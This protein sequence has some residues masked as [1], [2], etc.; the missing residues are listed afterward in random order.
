MK[1]IAA[2]SITAIFAVTFLTC[3]GQAGTEGAVRSVGPNP[4]GAAR[5]SGVRSA[6]NA[7]LIDL[8]CCW[9]DES[10]RVPVQE[11][12]GLPEDDGLPRPEH[13]PSAPASFRKGVGDAQDSSCLPAGNEMPYEI[14]WGSARGVVKRHHGF[15][16][17]ADELLAAS[18][19]IQGDPRFDYLRY[20]INDFMD[21]EDHAGRHDGDRV[22]L[23]AC[24]SAAR[25]SIGRRSLPLSRPVSPD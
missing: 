21:V 24:G 15:L 7:A 9:A 18:R 14:I 25:R 2:Q 23:P 22:F 5:T 3:N 16:C 12:Q 6:R 1:T 10:Y 4:S 13:G 20:I 17:S 8:G 19:E 11:T